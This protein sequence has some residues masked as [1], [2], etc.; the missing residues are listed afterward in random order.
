MR[1]IAEIQVSWKYQKEKA[2]P[3]NSNVNEMIRR[4]SKGTLKFGP[5]KF[6][7]CISPCAQTEGKLPAS[8]SELVK[9]LN[10]WQCR[11]ID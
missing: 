3:R 11:S 5:P 10:Q 8:C 6:K 2:N 7:K 1:K 4:A 9:C